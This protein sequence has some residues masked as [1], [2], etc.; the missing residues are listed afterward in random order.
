MALLRLK[1]RFPP[2]G[3]AYLPRSF[4]GRGRLQSD[5]STL[6]AAS[7]PRTDPFGE[8]VPASVL[9]RRARRL[10]NRERIDEKGGVC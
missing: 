6:T 9:R 1:G 7:Q 2:D 10:L 3:A 4:G 5:Y 8:T